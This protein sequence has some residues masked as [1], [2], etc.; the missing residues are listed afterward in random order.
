MIIDDEKIARD[1]L[2]EMLSAFPGIV[3]VIG[4]ASNGIEAV[5]KIPELSPDLIFIDVQMPGLNGFE[6]VRALKSPPVVVFTTAFEE[7]AIE[8]FRANAVDY[9]LKPVSAKEIERVLEKIRRNSPAHTDIRTVVESV[10]SGIRKNTLTRIKVTTGDT[11]RFVPV[12]TIMYF[13]ADEKYTTIGSESGTFVIDT[14]LAE[15]ETGLPS[16]EFIRIHRK[17]IVNVNYISQM[18]KWFDRKL[19]IELKGC[20]KKEF[21]VSRNYAD[22]INCL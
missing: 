9:L 12:D 13:E 7:Y 14:P 2:R 21:I 20:G 17:H 15:L 10:L 1:R 18:K 8:A 3:S 22:R 11:I 4:E 16:K 19:R 6:V 5:D